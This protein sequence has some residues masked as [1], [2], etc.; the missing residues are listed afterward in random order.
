VGVTGEEPP[1]LNQLSPNKHRH[2]DQQRRI[3]SFLFDQFTF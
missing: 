1:I 2:L 3:Y